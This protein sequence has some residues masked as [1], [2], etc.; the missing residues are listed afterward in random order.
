MTGRTDNDGNILWESSSD[1]FVAALGDNYHN[2]NIYFRALIIPEGTSSLI[3]NDPILR[4]DGL[5][6]GVSRSVR[7]NRITIEFTNAFG[8][9]NQLNELRSTPGSIKRRNLEDT[10]FD[11]SHINIRNKTLQWGVKDR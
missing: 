4:S 3:V 1:D 11:Q 2:S 6:K 10:T 8:K 5:L 7:D 9:L